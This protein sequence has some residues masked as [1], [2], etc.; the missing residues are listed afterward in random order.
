MAASKLAE[1]VTREILALLAGA[2]AVR[3]LEKAL[4]LMCKW[5]YV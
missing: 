1:N 4:R 2:P 3:N 5:R